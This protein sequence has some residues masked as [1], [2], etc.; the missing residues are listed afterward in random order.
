MNP[1]TVISLKNELAS[2]KIIA[3]EQ[4]KLYWSASKA[5]NAADAAVKACQNKIDEIVAKEKADFDAKVKAVVTAQ[6]EA[7]PRLPFDRRHRWTTCEERNAICRFVQA[8]IHPIEIALKMGCTPA[9]V[10]T[11]KNC[12]SWHDPVDEP[13]EKNPWSDANILSQK[14]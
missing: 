6:F 9:T 3:G 12:Y 10:S 4:N 2:L 8:G 1:E 13:S 14:I 11:Y 5:S 7:R